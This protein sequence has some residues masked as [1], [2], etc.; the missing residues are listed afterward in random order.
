MLIHHLLKFDKL[1]LKIGGEFFLQSWLLLTSFFNLTIVHWSIGPLDRWLYFNFDVNDIQAWKYISLCFWLYLSNEK[2]YQRSAGVKTTK[3]LRAYQILKK[4]E[5]LISGNVKNYQRSA[6]VKTIEFFRAFWV[7][8]WIFWYL[9]FW[10]GF[11]QNV[12]TDPEWE[13]RRNSTWKVPRDACE[14]AYCCLTFSAVRTSL[15]D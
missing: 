12:Q 14:A 15:L 1:L 11:H 8:K 3:F 6:G 9:Y 7:R 5:F 10:G 4:M 2:S 13:D